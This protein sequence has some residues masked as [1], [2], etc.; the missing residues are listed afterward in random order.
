MGIPRPTRPGGVCGSTPPPQTQA[1]AIR[2]AAGGRAGCCSARRSAPLAEA[3]TLHDALEQLYHPH[4]DFAGVGALAEAHI[5]R[6]FP[7]RAAQT[8][9]VS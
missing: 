3:K 7:A 5:R 9:G 4:V 6:L 1:A 2:T 8:E